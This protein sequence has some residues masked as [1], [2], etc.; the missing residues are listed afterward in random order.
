M[1]ADSWRNML[2]SKRFGE[3]SSDIWQILR[4]VATNLSIEDKSTFLAFR[5]T[6]YHHGLRTIG[7]VEK[8]NWQGISSA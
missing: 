7:V 2:L 3:L 8:N 1:D 4:K 6:P 5:L